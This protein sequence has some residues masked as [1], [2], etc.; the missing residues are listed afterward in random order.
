MAEHSLLFTLVAATV[1]AF[2]F[3]FAAQRLRIPPLVG[4]MLAGVV[5]GPNSPGFVADV[6]LAQEMAEI[7]VIL[8][9]FGV[10]LKI[11]PADLLR[12]GRVAIPGAIVQMATAT[13]LGLGAGQLLGFP[14][15]EAL[16]IG[17]ALSVASTV[18]LL[19]A[20]EARRLQDTSAGKLV[21]GWLVIEDIA[22][23]LAIV[24]MP[25]IVAAARGGEDGGALGPALLMTIGRIAA[26]VAL[27]I[28][29]G[30]R[31]FPW[32]IIRVAHA[33]SREL[34]SLA[35][36]ALA[37]G[38]AYVA[39]AIFDASF[40]LG[41]FLAGVALNGSR[42]SHNVAEHSLP[43]RDTFAVLFFVS[44]GML[45]DWRVLIEEPVAVALFLAVVVIGKGLVALAVARFLGATPLEQ[46]VAG[47]SL[48]QIGEFSFIL[49]GLGVSLGILSETGRDLVLATAL[50]SILVNPLLFRLV[51]REPHSAPA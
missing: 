42:M 27:M 23:V 33:R 37:L 15:A 6:A 40:A 22:I 29:V 12:H 11:S 41:A 35:S 34:L 4:Y 26:F 30:G 46:R 44:V 10:G 43:L 9:M 31:V 38:M 14:A 17:V 36:L 2:L 5:V 49:A 20:L 51:E 47:A 25:A 18:V 39:Y 13:V 48:A 45:F 28:I 16:T 50:L 24:A 3:G 1:L 7:G 19:R 21:V 32:L 8:L